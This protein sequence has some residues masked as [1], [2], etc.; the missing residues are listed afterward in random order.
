[1][2][3]DLHACTSAGGEGQSLKVSQRSIGRAAV[4]EANLRVRVNAWNAGI[5]DLLRESVEP[6]AGLPL[7]HVWAPDLRVPVHAEHADNDVGVGWDT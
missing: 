5:E 1:M 3:S 2:M 4:G 7:E 6:A